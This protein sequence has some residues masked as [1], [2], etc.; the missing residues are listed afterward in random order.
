MMSADDLGLECI[1]AAIRAAPPGSTLALLRDSANT[2][3][4]GYRIGP[5]FPLKPKGEIMATKAKVKS[6]GDKVIQGL[7]E[8]IVHTATGWLGLAKVHDGEPIF[9]L[10]A[11]DASAP[12]AVEVWANNLESQVVRMDK[13]NPKTAV[14]K[15]KIAGARAIAH[16]M[17]AWQE[18]NGSKIP[19]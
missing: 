15:R 3:V 5:L 4:G 14:L 13:A 9:V 11:H 19:D 7:R 18:L 10:R 8:A 1:A 12:A 6:K 16:Q 2:C 17:R